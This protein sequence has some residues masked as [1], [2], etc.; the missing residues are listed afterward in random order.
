MVIGPAI[1]EI[2]GEGTTPNFPKH[3]FDYLG[4][5][6]CNLVASSMIPT[7]LR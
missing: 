6:Y 5:S 4:I 2:V 3:I 1:P 7:R